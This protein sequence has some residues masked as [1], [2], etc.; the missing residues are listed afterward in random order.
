MFRHALTAIL[1]LVVVAASSEGRA[2]IVPPGA[3]FVSHMVRFEKLADFPDHAF[4]VGWHLTFHKP[5]GEWKVRRLA[6]AGEISMHPPESPPYGAKMAL[7]AVPKSALNA[8]DTTSAKGLAEWFEG[9]TPGVK[10]ADLD[11]DLIRSGPISD[12]RD[13]YWTVYQVR[14]G[15]GLQLERV[16]HDIPGTGL[17]AWSFLIAG[18]LVAAAAV[19]ALVLVIRRFVGKPKNA[20]AAGTA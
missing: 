19:T 1:A 6:D 2:D 16:R 13:E 4:F 12:P 8:G 9:K 7:A 15:E 3:K 11:V 20:P 18:V 14:L 10:L 17:A 5:E